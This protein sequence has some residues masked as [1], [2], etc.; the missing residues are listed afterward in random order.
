MTSTKAAIIA[1]LWFLFIYWLLCN[2]ILGIIKAH[3]GIAN[4]RPS[5]VNCANINVIAMG[6]TH[7]WPVQRCLHREFIS[8]SAWSYTWKRSHFNFFPHSECPPGQVTNFVTRECEPCPAGTYNDEFGRYVTCSSCPQGR[9]TRFNGSTSINDC[10][11]RKCHMM[12]AML[13]VAP[14][15]SSKQVVVK[16][17]DIFVWCHLP[18]HVVFTSF[19]PVNCEALKYQTINVIFSQDVEGLKINVWDFI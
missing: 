16:D 6:P 8:P 10:Y 1:N 12:N 14:K 11:Q 4:T 2:V 13:I 3:Y 5:D 19:R 9:T 17:P 18:K 15:Q 7:T